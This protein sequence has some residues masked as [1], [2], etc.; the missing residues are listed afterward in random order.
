MI[1]KRKHSVAERDEK[2]LR[3]G[4]V[5]AGVIGRRHADLL[6]G[7]S[8]ARLAA[9]CDINPA[10]CGLAERLGA[11]Y[12]PHVDAMLA[13]EVLDGVIVAAP[14]D[15][16]AAV[17]TA[18]ARRGLHLLVEKPLAHTLD[19]A[20]SLVD[21]A[22]QNGVQLLV[23]H[24]RRHNPRVQAARRIVAEGDIGRLVAVNVLWM[25]KKPDDYFDVAWRCQPGGGPFLIN[26]IHDIDTIRFVC[27]DIDRV[28][29]ETGNAVRGLAVEDS[30]SVCLHFTNGALG[31]MLVSDCTPSNWSYEQCTGENPFY[32]RTQ[33]DCYH[34]F[35]T[36][37][38]LAFPSMRR[39]RHADPAQSGWQHPLVEDRLN[40]DDR[41]PLAAQLVHFC[42]VIRGRARPRITGEDGYRTLAV[43]LGILVSARRGEPVCFDWNT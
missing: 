43:L 41:D 32:F 18:C 34:F 9:V 25:L 37:G 15:Q 5:G 14:T 7:M 40:V 26:L 24:H 8:G 10:V 36:R 11:A 4:I 23:G 39:I 28:F 27:G 31:T 19:A 29:A 6:G 33:G 21:A 3:L 35:G 1:E 16:H 17:G 20:R 12:H 42:D 30:G 38:A 22:T 13:A 2:T